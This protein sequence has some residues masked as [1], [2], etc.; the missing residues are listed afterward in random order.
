MESLSP[1]ES[2]S[3]ADSVLRGSVRAPEGFS[4]GKPGAQS[5]RFCSRGF[6]LG[7]SFSNLPLVFSIVAFRQL[8]SFGSSVR[9]TLHCLHELADEA[10]LLAN[11]MY[12]QESPSAAKSWGLCSL[13]FEASGLPWK[14]LQEASHCPLAQCEYP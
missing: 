1:Q 14:I 11:G 7:Y 9:F 10:S 6:A 5:P 13:G 12:T 4:E 8:P 3:G 2:A